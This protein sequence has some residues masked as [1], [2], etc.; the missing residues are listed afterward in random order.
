VKINKLHV[1]LSETEWDNKISFRNEFPT[2]IGDDNSK[3]LV[4]QK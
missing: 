3:E 2:K 4:I 1:F